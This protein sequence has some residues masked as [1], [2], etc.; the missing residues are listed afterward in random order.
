MA[1]DAGLPS[2]QGVI[3]TAQHRGGRN[4]PNERPA[5]HGQVS[6]NE[7]RELLQ[8]IINFVVYYLDFPEMS[9]PT[10]VDAETSLWFDETLRVRG[11][12]LKVSMWAF[13]DRCSHALWVG[14]RQP[15]TCRSYSP[16]H[17]L[18]SAGRCSA[19]RH[20]IEL[21]WCASVD[22]SPAQGLQMRL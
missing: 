22:S 19:Q 16:A 2:K 17:L 8:Y 11:E 21:C 1:A 9:R 15:R 10:A 14:L 5:H 4:L 7:F 3:E 13:V 18:C 6:I 20:R 12:P